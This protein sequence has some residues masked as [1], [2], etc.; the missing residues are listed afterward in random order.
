MLHLFLVLV[1]KRWGDIWL[2]SVRFWSIYGRRLWVWGFYV[3]PRIHERAGI[4]REK[5]PLP[6]KVCYAVSC[7]LYL[8]IS[9]DAW[10]GTRNYWSFYRRQN[11]RHNGWVYILWPF[12]NRRDNYLQYMNTV[13]LHLNCSDCTAFQLFRKQFRGGFVF[14]KQYLRTWSKLKVSY[15]LLNRLNAS[16]KSLTFSNVFGA[17]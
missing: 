2:S 14:Q 6:L 12:S 13:S 4:R 16:A 9:I 11:H 10:H 7:T 3:N 1:I 8:K 5:E 15:R 17:D